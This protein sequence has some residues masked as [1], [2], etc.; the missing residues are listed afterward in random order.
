MGRRVKRA[1]TGLFLTVYIFWRGGKEE[2]ALW[3]HRGQRNLQERQ[4]GPTGAWEGMQ[5][6][7]RRQE[8]DAEGCASVHPPP[9]R[10][11]RVVQHGA[12]QGE[13]VVEPVSEQVGRMTR[14]WLTIGEK[15]VC[16]SVTVVSSLGWQE[17]RDAEG[18][19]AF[20]WIEI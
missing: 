13:Q 1:G 10:P 2:P 4:E 16:Y 11:G 6:G 17:L 3:F 12:A 20:Q 19:L 9:P 7:T 5:G 15:W 18:N 8:D 14:F